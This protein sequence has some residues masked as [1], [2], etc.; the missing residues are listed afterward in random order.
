MAVIAVALCLSVAA[1]S[2]LAWMQ[3]RHP[4]DTVSSSSAPV[5]SAP[6]SSGNEELPVYDDTYSLV[7]V[8]PTSPLKSDFTLQ[9]EQ[10]GGVTVD[11]RIIPP[12]QRMM[13]DARTAGCP[14]KLTGGY[15]DAAQ[16]NAKFQAAV[17]SLM[18][19]QK[20]SQVR[21]ENQA[22]FT[23]GRAGYDEFQ[24]GMAVTFSAEG[25]AANTNFASTAQYQWLLKNSVQYGFILRYPADKT[26]ITGKGFDPAHFR[27]VGTEHAIKMREYAMSL[28]E[29][30]AYRKQQPDG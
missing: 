21:A 25:S 22:Q 14:L 26:D 9:P 17:Q 18:K 3:L 16:Q 8:T 27:Y 2:V 13:D 28:E 20:L 15:V 11:G 10:F 4:A 1:G 12:L 29:Y 5:S 19:N 24:T 30:S 7:L 6:P 23:V